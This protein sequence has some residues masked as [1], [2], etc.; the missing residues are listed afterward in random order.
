M[1]AINENLSPSRCHIKKYYIFC[2]EKRYV[3]MYEMLPI[4]YKDQ[5][6]LIL[7]NWTVK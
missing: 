3:G 2:L 1:T 5:T 6:H 7:I 4:T